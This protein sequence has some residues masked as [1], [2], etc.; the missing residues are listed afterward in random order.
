MGVEKP[1]WGENTNPFGRRYF[2]DLRFEKIDNFDNALDIYIDKL[3]SE[4]KD[5]LLTEPSEQVKE[6]SINDIINIPGG[7]SKGIMSKQGTMT[8]PPGRGRGR[9]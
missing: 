5:L 9:R 1:Q 4:T 3:K 8:K 6:S 2:T 7:M